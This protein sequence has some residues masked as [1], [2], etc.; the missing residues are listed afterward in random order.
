MKPT[1][2]AEPVMRKTIMEAARVVRA[3]PMPE[4]NCPTHKEVNERLRKTENMEGFAI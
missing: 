3:L 4:I 2:R 1:L